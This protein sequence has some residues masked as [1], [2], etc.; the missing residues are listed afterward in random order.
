MSIADMPEGFIADPAW[1]QAV[2]MACRHT[3][4]LIHA[5]YEDKPETMSIE[6]VAHLNIASAYLYLYDNALNNN[7]IIVAPAEEIIWH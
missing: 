4:G 3:V 6:E 1:L 2:A 5:T 7:D